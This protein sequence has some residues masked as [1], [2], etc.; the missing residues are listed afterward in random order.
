MFYFVEEDKGAGGNFQKRISAADGAVKIR[1][2]RTFE[3]IIF[4]SALNILN[5]TTITRINQIFFF[6]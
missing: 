2:Q 5:L 1:Q 4:L 3:I 6:F